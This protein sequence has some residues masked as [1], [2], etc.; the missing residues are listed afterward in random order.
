VWKGSWKKHKKLPAKSRGL[1]RLG[2]EDDKCLPSDDW[3]SVKEA[4][5]QRK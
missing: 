4:R 3:K 5:E 2:K 1:C